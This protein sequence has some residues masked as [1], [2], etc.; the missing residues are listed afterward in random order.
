VSRKDFLL[1]IW[2][3][4]LNLWQNGGLLNFLV[5]KQIAAKG[6]L[7]IF[8]CRIIKFFIDKII[9]GKNLE[10][11]ICHKLYFALVENLFAACWVSYTYWI[12]RMLF[13]RTMRKFE[14]YKLFYWIAK[15]WLESQCRFSRF[16]GGSWI[17]CWT[18]TCRD[19]KL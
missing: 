19:M 5:L 8:L 12:I 11:G 18:C 15:I 17:N 10:S 1:Y 3:T 7:S 9:H 2:K 4:A 16:E 14:F 6:F 13:M